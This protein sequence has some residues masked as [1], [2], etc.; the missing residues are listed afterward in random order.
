M[1]TIAN[2]QTPAQQHNSPSSKKQLALLEK[3]LNAVF[4]ER[5]SLIRLML[6]SIIAKA[7]GFLGGPPGTGKT[8]LV[9]AVTSAFGGFTFYYLFGATTTPDEIIVSI[10]LV[11]LQNGA[12]QR[13]LD[14][15]L[16]LSDTAI[17]DEIWKCNS[18][19]LNSM[20][21]IV[22]DKEYVNGKQVVQSSLNSLWG[23]SNE[24]PQDES[25][26]ALWDRLALRYWVTNVSRPAKKVLMMRQAGLIPTPATSVQFTLSDLKQMQA[27]AIQTPIEEVVIDCILDISGML[28][29]ETGL[30]ASTRKHN[31]IVEL[32]RCYAYV[33]G[34]DE[35]NEDHLDILEHILWNKP[36]E[37]ALIKKAIK[38]FGNPLAAQAQSILEAAQQI[39]ATI[40][41]LSL[42]MNRGQWMRDIGSADMQLTEI[43]AKLDE[44]IALAKQRRAKKVK[45]VKE[46]VASMRSSLQ[47]MIQTAYSLPTK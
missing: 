35:V 36:E 33:C 18:P 38:Q 37:R 16:V 2:N 20:L 10:D 14:R 4:L 3:E 25:L 41:P 30:I 34:D 43:E 5:D 22:L 7:N 44:T 17:A 11:A 15:K 6:T 28:E 46:Q 42:G 29:K 27:V 21:G 39:F 23:C 24:L 31:Q 1:T 8:S 13:D 32:M 12:F 26:N 45:Q 19:T 40:S 9:K 47:T